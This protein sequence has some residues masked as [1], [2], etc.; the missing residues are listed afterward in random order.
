MTASSPQHHAPL[1]NAQPDALID[2][3]LNMMEKS[4][5]SISDSLRQLASLEQKHA[6]TREAI[7]RAFNQLDSHNIRIREVELELPTLKMVRGWIIAGVL[8]VFGMLGIQ[9]FKMVS[10]H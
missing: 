4:L 3:R 10:G 2:Y 1:A 7:T 8:G 5:A 9:L 6:E